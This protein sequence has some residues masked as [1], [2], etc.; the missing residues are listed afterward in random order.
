VLLF[1]QSQDSNTDEAY[2]LFIK[3]IRCIGKIETLLA[4]WHVHHVCLLHIETKPEAG[5]T[6]AKTEADHPT[7]TSPRSHS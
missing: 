2:S 5:E 1:L 6:A 4:G 3:N 7:S